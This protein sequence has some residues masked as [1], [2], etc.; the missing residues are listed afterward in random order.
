MTHETLRVAAVAVLL[1]G[2]AL[3]I[4]LGI[5]A[6]DEIRPRKQKAELPFVPATALVACQAVPANLSEDIQE[7]YARICSTNLEVRAQALIRFPQVQLS[8]EGSARALE[9]V[10]QHMASGG[11]YIRRAEMRAFLPLLAEIMGTED[12]I[13]KEG[14][15]F[16]VA[17]SAARRMGCAGADAVPFIIKALQSR[18]GVEVHAGLLCAREMVGFLEWWE[19][20]SELAAVSSELLPH[21]TAVSTNTVREPPFSFHSFGRSLPESVKATEREL[22]RALPSSPRLSEETP[23][24]ESTPDD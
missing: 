13:T 21:V 1:A 4:L 23:P 19:L 17:A 16:S 9:F 20:T 18:K 8:D 12:F 11:R 24:R 7:L 15:R 5:K 3:L 22:R 2:L 10:K 6:P 14:R